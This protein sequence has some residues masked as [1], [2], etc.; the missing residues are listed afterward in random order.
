MTSPAGTLLGAAQ[1]E[2]D[3]AMLRRAFIETPDYHALRLTTDFNYVVGRRGTGKSAIFQRLR[4][5]FA[6]DTSAI[7]LAEQPQDYEM[8]ELQSLL[9]PLSSEYRVLRPTTRLLWTAHF[10]LDA[11]KAVS[12][13]YKFGKSLHNLYLADYLARHDVTA[14]M[15]GTAHCSATLRSILKQNLP[16]AQ[17]PGAIATAYEI[18]KLTDALREALDQAA[19]RVVAMYDGLDEAWTPAITPVAI[20]GGLA[21]TA[22]DYREKQFPIYPLLF[23]RDNMFRALA[24]LDE[25]FTRHIEGHSL[26]IHW[27]EESLFHLVVARLRVALN[28]E[29]LESPVKVWNRFAQRDLRDRSGFTRCLKYT[30]Y[31]PRDILVLLNEAYLNARRAGREA[32]VEK[33]VDKTAKDISQ[34]RLED[35]CKEYDKVLPGVRLFVSAFRGQPA[36][37]P[38]AEVVNQLEEASATN[39]Y[40]DFASRDLVLFENGGEMFSAL[41]SVGFVGVKDDMSG[42]Y[43]FCHDG[44]M[45]A[46]VTL[47]GSRD[48]LVHPCYWKALDIAITEDSG[49]VVL[50]V[51]DEYEV[52]PTEEPV[53]LRLQRLGRVPEELSGIPEGK[54]GSKEF[55]AWVL[56]A[57]R[58]LFSGALS[59]IELKP[60]PHTALNQRDIVATNATTSQFWRRIYEDYQSRQVVFECKNYSELTPEDVRQ[61]LDYTSSE[62]GRFAIAVRRGPTDA[63]SE[64]EKERTK[65]LF[66]EHKRLLLILP[67]PMLVLCIRKLRTPKKYDYPEFTI[68]KHLDYV[69]RSVLSMTHPPRYRQKRKK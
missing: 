34:H 67:S 32:I 47:G 43:M 60:N 50:E 33:D 17:I 24:Q 16:A 38:A 11:T 51:N 58:L 63:L 41:Y 23:V 10:L 45:A 62:Y 65:A 4:Q 39:D 14:N 35:L 59:N 20:L 12:R 55:E 6:Q 31:R 7:L 29:E 9:E 8:L 48:T 30:L 26:R 42:N 36:A 5:Y 27:D 2:A 57:V 52:P 15:S 46:L 22:A 25:D 54:A 68:S 28:L 13:H 3:S 40:S 18:G 64:S 37:R 61:I 21:K 44:T 53:A 19:V 66:Y 69:V 56:R 1:A 49:A